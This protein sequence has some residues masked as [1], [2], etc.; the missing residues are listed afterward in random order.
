MRNEKNPQYVKYWHV[1][2]RKGRRGVGGVIRLGCV[3]AYVLP[4]RE[5]VIFDK[6][7][8]LQ[9]RLKEAGKWA[10]RYLGRRSFKQRKQRHWTISWG[11]KER[12]KGKHWHCFLNSLVSCQSCLFKLACRWQ[13]L[14]G[15]PTLIATQAFDVLVKVLLSTGN[16]LELL[17]PHLY[18]PLFI[19]WLM[20]FPS[21]EIDSSAN[22]CDSTTLLASILDFQVPGFYSSGRISLYLPTLISPITLI[23]DEVFIYHMT[24]GK[25]F[26]N[27]FLLLLSTAGPI[28]SPPVPSLGT[29]CKHLY[30]CGMEG[31]SEDPRIASNCHIVLL[32]CLVLFWLRNRQFQHGVDTNCPRSWAQSLKRN[33]IS[34]SSR[35]FGTLFPVLLAFPMF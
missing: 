1:L 33:F 17:S 26:P 9:W 3:H 5:V 19:I 28:P 35:T 6:T 31:T 22:F 24:Y 29:V 16:L 13:P 25:Y 23:L 7:S 2:R 21:L 4:R 34:F 32:P 11:S 15:L 8:I 10:I 20:I 18:L 27:Q 14:H 12:G 30:V